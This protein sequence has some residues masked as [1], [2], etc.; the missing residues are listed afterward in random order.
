MDAPEKGQKGYMSAKNKLQK[1]KGT[2][3][4]LRPKGKSYGRT[5]AEVISKR[6]II[7]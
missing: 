3:V 6:R 2:T 4:T 1:L 7:K 5:V